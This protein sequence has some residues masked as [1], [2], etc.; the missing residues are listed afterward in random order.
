MKQPVKLYEV[1]NWKRTNSFFNRLKKD[2]KLKRKN[3][4]TSKY[5]YLEAQC[6]FSKGSLGDK[7]QF[8]ST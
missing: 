1:A 3:L 6:S 5:S 2:T 8:N 7:V 4:E